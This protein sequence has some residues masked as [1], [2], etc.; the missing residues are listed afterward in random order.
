MGDKH[1]TLFADSRFLLW[2][3]VCFATIILYVI[4]DLL[5]PMAFGRTID[6]IRSAMTMGELTEKAAFVL[7]IKGMGSI[8][9]AASQY[10][11]ES[12][13]VRYV[14]DLR[15]R[16]YASVLRQPAEVLRKY[17]HPDL[18]WRATG[19]LEFI[20][21]AINTAIPFVLQTLLS[22]AIA[23]P[24]IL[25]ICPGMALLL[26]VVVPVLLGLVIV[27]RKYA[28]KASV[29]TQNSLIL[30]LEHLDESITGMKTIQAYGLEKARSAKFDELTH[31]YGELIRRIAR[32]D[33][34]FSPLIFFLV[35]LCFM[36]NTL[37]GIVLV[38]EDRLTLGQFVQV[39]G[40]MW[41]FMW[42]L[43]SLGHIIAIL[44]RGKMGV[45]RLNEVVKATPLSAASSNGGEDGE[46]NG[47][48]NGKIVFDRVTVRHGGETVLE[49]LSLI[50]QGGQV[51]AIIGK[52]GSGKSMMMRLLLR[53]CDPSHGKVLIDDIP[54]V[55]YSLGEL[56]SRI[57]FVAQEP[58]LFSG[59]IMDNIAIGCA[60]ATLPE[61]R[62]AAEIADF[63]DDIE[64]FPEG[65]ETPVG[66]QGVT[67]SGGQKQRLAIARAVLRNPRI[68]ILDD[69][70]SSVDA[71]T[72]ERIL[73]RLLKTGT[74]ARTTILISHH[75]RSVRRAEM[76]YVLDNG[77][78][79]EQ[80]SHAQL[81]AY[82]GE[83]A[84]LCLSREK[85]ARR[86]S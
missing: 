29:R 40:Y 18:V 45:E 47:I 26:I 63:L 34:V 68:L 39:T 38:S 21:K 14:A 85:E 74:T 44:Q 32:I 9:Y 24:L 61:I 27:V 52:S 82:G 48:S 5:T 59:T 43:T 13:A 49:D 51:A 12:V 7:M 78:I 66:E 2:T 28:R 22:T 23:I 36:V 77:V 30:L 1:R 81:L 58:F 35:G 83:Y 16:Y 72:E 71:K 73:A 60:A 41:Q 8:V 69:A 31:Q 76:I 50:I 17:Q 64:S 62:R 33:A 54:V 6:G 25:V 11:S 55:E 80:G 67:L 86:E 79:S 3:M 65:F 57:S 37:Y 56:R 19:D 53:S 42:P 70:L 20:R 84:K 15:T 4:F 75:L 46:K 10:A